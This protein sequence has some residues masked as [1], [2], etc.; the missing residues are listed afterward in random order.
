MKVILLKDVKNLGKKYEVKEVSDGYGRN[1]LLKNGLAKVATANDIKLAKRKVKEEEEKKEKEI[2]EVKETA[3][4][5][6]GQEVK[7]EMKVG[8]KEQ[9]FEA[10]TAQ[11]IAEKIKETGFEMEEENVNLEE[12]IKALGEYEV[13]L[14]LKHGIKSSV[15]IIITKEK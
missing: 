14:K 12:P 13:E 6:R 15:K 5:L 7:V 10:V 1:F 4:K 11:K 9:L 2:E 3:E 8:E